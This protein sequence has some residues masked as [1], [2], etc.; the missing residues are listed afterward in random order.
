MESQCFVAVVWREVSCEPIELGEYL[1]KKKVLGLI[2]L[3]YIFGGGLVVSEVSSA[4]S[5]KGFSI[6]YSSDERGAITP[7]G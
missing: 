3:T 7:C 5:N 4:V 2:I 6:I 1:M